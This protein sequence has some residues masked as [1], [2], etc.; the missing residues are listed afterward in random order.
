MDS[1]KSTT[2]ETAE[3]KPD[4]APS[5]L[6]GDMTFKQALKKLNIED[7]GE[8]IWHSNSHGELMHIWD[9]ISM[10]QNIEGDAKWFRPLFEMC[11]KWTAENWSR[12]ESC[13]QHMPRL[14]SDFAK[15]LSPN[16]KVSS[17]DKP[18]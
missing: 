5:G 11:V 15:A 4:C 8:R 12:P 7:Y 17:G 13:Y 10:A 18:R 1:G 14:M 16:T 6:L 3:A 2:V 9:Y